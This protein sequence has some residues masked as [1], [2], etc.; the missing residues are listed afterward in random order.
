MLVVGSPRSGTTLLRDLLRSHPRL[1]FPDESHV[2]PALRRLHGDPADERRARLLAADLLGA[3]SIREWKL[4][5]RVADLAGER[6]FAGM[7]ARLYETWARREGKPRW[8][9]KTPLYA[10]ELPAALTVFPGAQVVHVVRDGRAVA[11]SL[12]RQPWGPRTPTRAARMWRRCVEAARRDGEPLGPERYFEVRFEQL[13]R[14]PEHELRRLCAFLG[15]EFD[16]ALLHPARLP[17]AP[18]YAR[19]WP[20]KHESAIDPEAGR[21]PALPADAL[22]LFEA[23]AGDTLRAFAYASDAAPRL[24]TVRERAAGR[25]RDAAAQLHWRAT[26]RDRVPRVATALRLGRAH[27][28]HRAGLIGQR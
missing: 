17:P 11:E 1:T 15:E 9:D 20:A 2:L 7:V 4:G 5:L 25:A 26:T 8:G 10:L 24:P 13:V 28:L 22:A 3:F 27:A 6:S 12:L 16:A 23:E 14:E 18:G 19:P 21:A